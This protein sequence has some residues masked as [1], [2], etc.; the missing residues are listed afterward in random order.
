MLIKRRAITFARNK[1][2]ESSKLSPNKI[3]RVA[4]R[5]PKVDDRLVS[6]QTPKAKKK[7]EPQPKKAFAQDNLWTPYFKMDSQKDV[8][9][10]NNNDIIET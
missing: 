9:S 7:K 10:A 2:S 1:R 6:E 5:S 8:V 3:L 4:D